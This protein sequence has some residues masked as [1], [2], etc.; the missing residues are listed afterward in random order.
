MNLALQL[1]DSRWKTEMLFLC[2][3]YF[4]TIL[5]QFLLQSTGMRSQ[6]SQEETSVT[7]ASLLQQKTKLRLSLRENVLL[8]THCRVKIKAFIYKNSLMGWGKE[9]QD[10]E[11]CDQTSSK[12]GSHY[13]VWTG[14]L[15]A[16]FEESWKDLLNDL[17]LFFFGCP[18]LFFMWDQKEVL[19]MIAAFAFFWK[20]RVLNW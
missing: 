19:W 16:K 8:L 20:T 10:V 1:S 17:F 13:S 14:L 11:K 9:R 4:Y 7:A 2:F 3:D 5:L 18:T 6:R 15:S 12:R